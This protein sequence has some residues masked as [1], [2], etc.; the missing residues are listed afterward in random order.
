MRKVAFAES[1]RLNPPVARVFRTATRDTMI[2]EVAVAAGDQVALLFSAAAQDEAAFP[3]P[4][5]FRLDRGADY[6]D[7]G[8][9]ASA[10]NCFGEQIAKGIF[11]ALVDELLRAARPAFAPDVDGLRMFA[12]QLPD[13]MPWTFNPP[14]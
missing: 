12:G 11:A 14:R 1:L 13:D 10:H 4:S 5:A 2:A 7:F 8:H 9:I 6:L 3:E